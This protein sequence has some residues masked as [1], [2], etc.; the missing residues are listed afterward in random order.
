MAGQAVLGGIVPETYTKG[1]STS[2][3]NTVSSSQTESRTSG[4]SESR[5]ENTTHTKGVTSGTS[6]NVQLTM[7]NKSLLDTMEKIEQQLKRIDECESVGMWEC[8]AYILSDTQETAEMAAGT[9]K[10]LMKGEQSG[11]ET[12]SVNLWGYQE[13]A[14][15]SILKDYIT[16][17]IHP[18]FEY[19]SGETKVPV[20][21]ASLVSSN[22]LAIQMGLPRKSVCGFPVIE[23][24]DFGKEGV[25]H[26][27]DHQYRSGSG[28][29]FPDYAHL[30]H[31][32]Y[33]RR[34]KQYRL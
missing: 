20:T 11:V 7:Q 33:R 28:Q 9:Y 26:G 12:S 31:R 8:A 18:V 23:H 13:K 17:F 4:T 14:K 30:R 16:N 34:E 3:S 32:F 25:Q 6:N 1:T 10:A 19:H 21:S 5:S 24:A 22:E 29:R 15:V 2:T 27:K